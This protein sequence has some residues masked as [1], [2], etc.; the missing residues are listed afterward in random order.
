MDLETN[1][2][3][4]RVTF[5]RFALQAVG[6][7]VLLAVAGWWLARSRYGA[8]G[9]PAVLTGFG[10]SLLAALVSGWFLELRSGKCRDEQ[11]QMLFDSLGAMGIR[12]LVITALVVIAV[13]SGSFETTPLLLSVAVGYVVLLGVETRYALALA[14]HRAA[15][16]SDMK[17]SDMKQRGE[18]QEMEQDTTQ[19]GAGR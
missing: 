1:T 17:P 12:L 3:A 19:T 14:A 5:G 2:P 18:K 4:L 13:L 8:A 16:Q 15:R 9:P 6:L 11:P 10:I 7:T